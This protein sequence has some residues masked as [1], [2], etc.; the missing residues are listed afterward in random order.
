[1]KKKKINILGYTFRIEFPGNECLM[2]R[3]ARIMF[4]KRVIHIATEQ[5]PEEEISCILHEILEGLN[6]LLQLD[7]PHRTM[8]RLET[9]LFQVLTQNGVDISPLL[10]EE[11]D[12][13]PA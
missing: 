9:G 12:D 4:D 13:F 2:D 11:K 5:D 7:L 10:E 1:M 3:P 6:H 8:T